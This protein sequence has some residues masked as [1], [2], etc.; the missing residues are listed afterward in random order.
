MSTPNLDTY[1]KAHAFNM[2]RAPYGTVAE[3]GAGQETVRW[4]FKVGGA[5]GSIAKSLS[6][7]D[8]KFS[9]SIYGDCKRYVSRERLQSM[10][11]TEYRL[12]NERL[13]DERGTECTFFAFA[14]T[15][16]TFSYTHKTTGHG[17]LGIKFQ[18]RPRE[19]PSQ[20]DLHVSLK[21]N[22]AGQDQDTLGV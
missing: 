13:D 22:S 6:A 8:M 9:D 2:D 21:G 20:I 1:E 15:V 17:W 19:Q 5:A 16:A 7:Y 12:L 4:F 18:T 10:L 3:I 14:N 11:N